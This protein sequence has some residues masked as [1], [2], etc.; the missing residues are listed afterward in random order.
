M[1]QYSVK[2]ALLLLERTPSTLS[3]LL[4][5]LPDDWVMRNEG[6][7][8][9]SP[10]EVVGHLIF[11]EKNNFFGRIQTILSDADQK[12]L[13]PFDMSS[14]FEWIKDKNM[15]TLLTEFTDLRKQNLASLRS[16]PLSE[17]DLLKTGLHPKMGTVTLQH[18]LSTWVTHDLSHTTQ[19][20][21]VM[22]RQYKE[23]VGPFIEFLRILN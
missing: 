7:G 18:V 16:H 6:P 19:I 14:Q 17:A 10:W 11:C 1:Q 2:T 8:T 20:L 15:R 12:P 13:S 23:D 22:A 9:W 21:R 4:N 3:T 5:G